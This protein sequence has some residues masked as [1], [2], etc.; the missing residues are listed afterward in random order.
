[1][2]NAEDEAGF[3]PRAGGDHIPGGRPLLPEA[4]E[5]C[6]AVARRKAAPCP[7]LRWMFARFVTMEAVLRTWSTGCPRLERECARILRGNGH[8]AQSRELDELLIHCRG[9]SSTRCETPTVPT[10]LLVD[11]DV[12][13]LRSL[14]RFLRLHHRVL[15]AIS[16]ERALLVLNTRRIDVVISDFEMPGEQDGLAFLQNVRVR[17]PRVRRALMSGKPNLDFRAA[18]E[19]HLIETFIPK[20]SDLRRLASDV[21]RMAAFDLNGAT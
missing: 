19:T 10:L 11:D 21:A 12:L 4:I 16:P 13:L 9:E 20:G 5:L 1:M 6:R 14:A 8:T 7:Y 15:H 18:L 3:V 2:E 17:F